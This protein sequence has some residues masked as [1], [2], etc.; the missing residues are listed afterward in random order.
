MAIGI[1]MC[2]VIVQA[3]KKKDPESKVTPEEIWNLSPKGNLDF[4]I[5]MY[6]EAK[7][8]LGLLTKENKKDPTVKLFLSYRKQQEE[9][10][11]REG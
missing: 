8:Q 5:P 10:E 7:H 2:E 6:I 1:R 9:Q 3:L 4:L 11:A